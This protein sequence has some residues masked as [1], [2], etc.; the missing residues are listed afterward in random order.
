MDLDKKVKYAYAEATGNVKYLS[1]IEKLCAPLGVT[2][3]V[4]FS[5]YT[6]TFTKPSLDLI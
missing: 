3:L 1:T 6:P 2:D 4:G 5:S